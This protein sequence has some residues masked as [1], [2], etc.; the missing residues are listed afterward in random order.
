MAGT[1]V[2]L[3]HR[4]SI[5][6]SRTRGWRGPDGPHHSIRGPCTAGDPG[7]TM[8]NKPNSQGRDCFVASLLAMTGTDGNLLMWPLLGGSEDPI[9]RNKANWCGGRT[10]VNHWWVNDL[11][12]KGMDGRSGEAKPILGAR[13]AWFA[14]R[15]ARNGRCRR[16][17]HDLTPP[18][19]QWGTRCAKQSQFA[20]GQN[21]P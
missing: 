14:L 5:E 19:W 18:G 3:A 15:P 2:S 7:P 20:G 8:Q 16:R 4:Q 1:E 21:E 9:V 17:G 11:G 10:N 13:I 6:E 12:G